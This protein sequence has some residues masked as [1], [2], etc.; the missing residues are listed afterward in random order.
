MGIFKFPF[1]KLKFAKAKAANPVVVEIGNDWLKIAGFAPSPSGWEITGLGLHKL[2]Q[3][4]DS[5]SATIGDVFKELS[6]SRHSVV[7]CI[8]RH[9]MTIRVL[10]LPSTDPGEINDMINLQVGKQTPYSK[11]S[12]VFAHKTM[13]GARQGYTKVMLAVAHR[14]IVNERIETL[15]NA[16]IHTSKVSVSSEGVY[17]WFELSYMHQIKP[18]DAETVILL[19]I[20]SNYSDFIALRNGK[21]VFT[22][23]LF[24]GANHLADRSEPWTDRLIEELKRC[25]KRYYVEERNTRIAKM[26]LTGAVKSIEELD[27]MLPSALD[28]AVEKTDTFKK[29]GIRPGIRSDHEQNMKS[30]SLT[31]L[32]GAGIKQ[33]S[34]DL[35]LIPGEQKL[36]KA[37]EARRKDLT[38][39]GALI[40]SIVMALSFL[41]AVSY[42]YKSAYLLQLKKEVARISGESGDIEKKRL[43][44][45]LVKRN[46][47]AKNSS[48]II[49]H[50]IYTIAPPEIYFRGI[51]ID[52]NKQVILKGYGFAMSDVFKFIKKLEESKMF[53]NVK[54]SYTRT[55]K[56]RED[57]REVEYAE[58][59]IVC[60]YESGRGVN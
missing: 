33:D 10:D 22:K 60:P 8:P 24:I 26:Y 12:I 17:N 18:S 42:Y 47:D 46:L 31:S 50:E 58:F 15:K 37:M 30:V 1:D 35:D 55:K 4:K 52:E 5:I 48:L 32:I 28:M 44:I 16:G 51:D 57:D 34:L 3:I 38:V 59:E 54:A 36:M 43:S 6:L 19:D 9:L 2:A 14:N 29:T 53:A 27:A 56:E 11:D 7:L 49:L 45:E 25:V 20:D 40:V 23:N 41:L 39:M 21:M 13:L